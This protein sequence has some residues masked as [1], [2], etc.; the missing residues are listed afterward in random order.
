MKAQNQLPQDYLALPN[1]L[2]FLNL[3]GEVYLVCPHIAKKKM[4]VNIMTYSRIS[5]IYVIKLFLLGAILSSLQSHPIVPVTVQHHP[6][7]AEVTLTVSTEDVLFYCCDR[8][9]CTF[10]G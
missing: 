6:G 1:I 8:K 10:Y 2:L 7:L 9:R 3:F 5:K 4:S